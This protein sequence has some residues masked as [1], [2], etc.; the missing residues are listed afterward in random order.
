M[1]DEKSSIKVAIRIKPT[2]DTIN[3]TEVNN[4][5]I[6]LTLNTDVKLFTFNHIFDVSNNNNDV[7][8]SIGLNI[9]K[10][11]FDGYNSCLFAYGQSGS[12]KT[13]T[14]TGTGE[15][16]G[17]I[18]NI[19]ETLFNKVDYE[20]KVEVSYYEIYM[21]KINDL[22]SKKEDLKIRQ[23]PTYGP[24][25]TDLTKILVTDN[26]MIQRLIDK[27]NMQRSVGSTQLNNKSSRSHAILTINFTQYKDTHEINSKLHLIDLAGSEKIN[28]SEVKGS[29]MLESIS[30]NKSLTTLG[31]V[32]NELVKSNGTKIKSSGVSSTLGVPPLGR[33]SSTS[34]SMSSAPRLSRNA[35]PSQSAN[36]SRSS[37]PTHLNKFK[38]SNHNVTHTP[39]HGSAHNFTHN[40]THSS[41]HNINHISFRESTLTYLLSESL[42]G[43]SKTYMIATISPNINNY[44]ETLNTLRYATN[45]SKI[46]NIVK[47]NKESNEEIVEVLKKEIDDLKKRLT[48]KITNNE[49]VDTLKKELEDRT[50]LLSE[51]E[52][53]W[54]QKLEESK[55]IHMDLEY[56]F[57]KE[58][59]N[60]KLEYNKKFTEYKQELQSKQSVIESDK[61]SEVIRDAV[62]SAMLPFQSKHYDTIDDHTL[63]IPNKHNNVNKTTSD[64]TS[65]V[66]KIVIDNTSTVEKMASDNASAMEKMASD[67]ASAMEKMASDNASAMEKMTSDNTSAMEKLMLD[68]TLVIDNITSIHHVEIENY[69]K[70]IIGLTNTIKIITLE[71]DNLLDETKE[72]NNKIKKLV[73]EIKLLSDKDANNIDMIDTLTEQIHD[74]K[75]QI[76]EF[77]AK[78]SSYESKIASYESKVTECESKIV[79]CESKIISYESKILDHES[80][81]NDYI[82]KNI[83][84]ENYASE[85]K[86]QI[87]KITNENYKLNECVGKLIIDNITSASNYNTIIDKL[88]SDNKEQR[89]L[90]DTMMEENIKLSLSVQE[91][92]KLT[93]TNAKL[94]DDNAKLTDDNAKL[95][96]DNAKLTDDNSKLT[97]DNAKL[98]DDNTKLTDDNTKLTD[99]NVDD[100]KSTDNN[101]DNINLV[102]EIKE[103]LNLVV[104]TK[105]QQITTLLDDQKTKDQQ[106]N[107]LLDD[108]KTKDQQITTLLDDQK[109]KD[110]QITTLLDDQKTKDQQ[111]TTLLDDQKDKNYQIN[112]LHSQ[113]IKMINECSK[114]NESYVKKIDEFN[115]IDEQHTKLLNENKELID[116]FNNKLNEINNKNII[117]DD[118]IAKLTNK[119]TEYINKNTELTDKNT[120][121]SDKN[122]EYINK[123][124]ELIGKNT[125]L[126]SSVAKLTDELNTQ[127]NDVNKGKSDYANI[128]NMK[129]Q[130]C[131]LESE[132]FIYKKQTFTLRGELISL[133]RKFDNEI[134]NNINM[135]LSQNAQLEA[136]KSK[137]IVMEREMDHH[138]NH[139]K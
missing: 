40:S 91:N 74:Y 67:N 29:Q 105:D 118:I 25:V 109:T 114:I 88:T 121:L 112:L 132:N 128:D 47:V 57:N 33:P 108:Q 122:T 89:I 23:H 20:I 1:N 27:G 22:L 19:C 131:G 65:T 21:E 90:T 82:V 130:M 95:T 16:P 76:T 111:I 15:E 83:K 92:I 94:T 136:L 120:E 39:T 45:V 32:I 85:C 139:V 97:N 52:K 11:V 14:M 26:L 63:I 62:Q 12:G 115:K 46:I 127:L 80:I 129:V 100:A 48:N 53:S 119:N 44:N 69:N 43:N 9:V 31:K 56:K 99:D 75:E 5:N 101:D 93:C 116:R 59:E 51:K 72:L 61:L 18:P 7:Y 133:Q 107:T 55:K 64:N 77:K 6:K 8:Q 106:I 117:N 54:V 3:I 49:E 81:I 30:I 28:K 50:L 113:N 34:P 134:Q 124:N 135:R 2:D 37:S 38:I 58:I 10:N 35:S 60:T 98:T 87:D 4:N 103:Q 41:T 13:F 102:I 36:S 84:N 96:D 86:D 123:N 125:D 73:D 42:G 137:I 68:H 110:Q 138:K 78:I 66:E 24:F 79:E 104:K 70:N 17:I 126:T 71:R